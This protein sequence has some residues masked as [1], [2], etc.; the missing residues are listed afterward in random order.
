MISTL[1]LLKEAEIANKGMNRR[2]NICMI[3]IDNLNIEIK[4]LKEK[5][6]LSENSIMPIRESLNR[7]TAEHGKNLRKLKR[8]GINV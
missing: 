8:L 2:I 6:K 4:D 5:L 1:Q 3:E 7:M